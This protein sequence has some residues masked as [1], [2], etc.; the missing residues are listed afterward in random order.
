M[1]SFSTILTMSPLG[2]EPYPVHLSIWFLPCYELCIHHAIYTPCATYSIPIFPV[3]PSRLPPKCRITGAST[4]QPAH[5]HMLNVSRRSIVNGTRPC[6]TAI[7]HTPRN[8]TTAIYKMSCFRDS[9]ITKGD[10]CGS[11]PRLAG[12]TV[13]SIMVG[14]CTP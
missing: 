2:F 8:S 12:V 6:A 3:P 13:M 14:F 11:I 10:S 5:P 9:P 1:C 4:S 7:L